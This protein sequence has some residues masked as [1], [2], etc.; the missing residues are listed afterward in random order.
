MKHKTLDD[1][2]RESGYSPATVSRVMNNAQRVSDRTKKAVLSAARKLGCLPSRRT[3]AILLPSL[4]T[5]LYFQNVLS[6][7][8]PQLAMEGFRTEIVPRLR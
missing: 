2:A 6:E 7:I 8:G 3:V 4:R 1:V 5:G